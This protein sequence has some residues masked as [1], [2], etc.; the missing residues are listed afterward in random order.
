VRG[1]VEE[2]AGFSY[3]EAMHIICSQEKEDMLDNHQKGR[4]ASGSN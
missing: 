1:F 4:G 2:L 3:T